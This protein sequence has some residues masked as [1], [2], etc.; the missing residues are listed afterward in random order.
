VEP[1]KLQQF[2]G[3]HAAFIAS[4]AWNMRNNRLWTPATYDT[5]SWQ[6]ASGQMDDRLFLE[7]V[8]VALGTVW[9]PDAECPNDAIDTYQVYRDLW[10]GVVGRPDR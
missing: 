5:S 9:C 6:S 3:Y 8:D 1:T 7:D 2:T 10:M 4:I